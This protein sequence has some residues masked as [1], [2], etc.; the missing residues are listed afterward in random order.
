MND[1]D[2]EIFYYISDLNLINYYMTSEKSELWNLGAPGRALKYSEEIIKLSEGGDIS[3][4]LEVRAG[5]QD[6]ELMYE[7]GKG[8][9]SVY[10]NGYHYAQMEKGIFL[11]R[12]IYIPQ[13]TEETKE[14]YI[15]AAQKRIN[16]YLGSQN[17]VIVT[18]GGRLDTLE[19]E[20]EDENIPRETT[21]G[22]YYNIN[23]KG[24]IYK[25]YIMKGSKEELKK[26]EYKG[27]HIKSDIK[28][29]S[30]DSTIPLDTHITVEHIK[31]DKI[32]KIIG[33]DNYNAYD[34]KLYSDSKKEWIKKLENGKFSV[35][36]PV[37]DELNGKMVT[38]YYI[39]DNNE[40]EEY[41]TI[42]ENGYAMFETDH[43]STYILAEKI[44][45]KEPANQPEQEEQP[46]IAKP[47]QE[48]QKQPEDDTVSKEIIPN[49]GMKRGIITFIFLVIISRIIYKK[50]NYMK[51]I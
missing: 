50:Y 45:E 16:D 1:S 22:N 25:F 15:E 20:W 19:D 12:V 24:K 32:N 9:M 39:N 8:G 14:S 33:T 29:T 7:F 47:E 23:I 36:I 37:G 30:K 6:E 2:N 34:I 41:E 48:E 17:E 51:G 11:K 46:E 28:V 31:D 4:Y 5:A 40:V 13:N 3:F 10:Y 18:Y 49:A 42:V 21:D 35:S 44:E 43:F 38:T 26:P 27:K